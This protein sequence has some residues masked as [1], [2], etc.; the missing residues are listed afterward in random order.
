MKINSLKL[1]NW[2]Q[3]AHWK[4]DGFWK[5]LLSLGAPRA[6]NSGDTNPMLPT[7]LFRIGWSDAT[8]EVL[9]VSVVGEKPMKKTSPEIEWKIFPALSWRIWRNLESPDFPGIWKNPEISL[10]F[11]LFYGTLIQVICPWCLACCPK[12]VAFE[13]RADSADSCWNFWWTGSMSTRDPMEFLEL[14][15]RQRWTQVAWRPL[16]SNSAYWWP[17]WEPLEENGWIFWIQSA[18]PKLDF[19]PTIATDDHLWKKLRLKVGERS[20]AVRCLLF[21][22]QPI[23][24]RPKNWLLQVVKDSGGR[25]PESKGVRSLCCTGEKK[26]FSA[27]VNLDILEF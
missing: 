3:F 5:I 15:K 6:E 22:F 12:S 11:M 21:R 20:Q 26:R 4:M 8:H 10:K 9:Q 2:Q 25:I 18:D 16:W 27:A 23:S 17:T 13:N 19:S 24:K 7:P 14:P 1:T